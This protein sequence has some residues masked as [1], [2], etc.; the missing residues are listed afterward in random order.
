[1][2]LLYR[3]LSLPRNLDE[4]VDRAKREK[5]TAIDVLITPYEDKNVP[6]PHDYVCVV[7]AKA[8]DREMILGR[9]PTKQLPFHFVYQH[10][11][12]YAEVELLAITTAL[13]SAERITGLGLEATVSGNPIDLAREAIVQ[14]QGFISDVERHLEHR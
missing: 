11:L 5:V 7:S 3:F 4:F 14:Y 13:K 6:A 1:M 12:Y 9:H 10:D 2:S 8:D